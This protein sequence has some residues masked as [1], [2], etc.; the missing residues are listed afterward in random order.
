MRFIK[1]HGLGNDFILLCGGM[2]GAA[3]P[4]AAQVVALCDRRRG[5]GA[6]GVMLARPS[7]RAA[8]RMELVNADG[9][10]PEMCG[11]GLRCL[12]KYAVEELGLSGNPLEVE[13]LAGVLRCE[14]RPG[15]GSADG[16]GSVR[17]A[18]GRP[19]F[20][21]SAVPMTGEG[22]SVDV[23]VALE[24][25]SFVATGVNMGNPH[26]VIFGQGGRPEA[27][28]WGPALAAHPMWPEGANVEF[29]AVRA[30]DEIDVTVWERGCGLTEACG[31]GAT[32]TA[33]AAVRAGLSRPE[34]PIAVHLPGGTLQITVA[35]DL[36][37]AWMAG[38]AV[39]V[40]RG[41]VTLRA[42][43]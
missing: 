10:V 15:D 4:S 43:R 27:E 11:N 18:M 5:V 7:E 39:E 14:H 34:V 32:A 19:R 33:A 26:M 41:A 28:R 29:A 24:A 37:Q 16:V 3:S 23:R 8:L 9:S 30:P 38:P 17:V 6:D 25:A 13:T 12:V 22:S 2:E 21:R 35:A 20:E 1:Y 42:L 40:Y 36:S 31:T